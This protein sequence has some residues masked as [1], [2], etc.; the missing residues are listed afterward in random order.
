MNAYD[1][2]RRRNVPVPSFQLLDPDVAAADTATFFAGDIYPSP[3]MPG[4]R[5]RI[6]TAAD[7]AFMTELKAAGAAG[8]ARH[9]KDS[10][11][12]DWA[13]CWGWL[14]SAR[15]SGKHLL[16]WGINETKS[17]QC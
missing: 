10:L 14:E 6:A 9:V 17:R 15:G 16:K 7:L 12:L 3:E 11:Q 1:P 5:S 8:C 2:S 4:H 13:G